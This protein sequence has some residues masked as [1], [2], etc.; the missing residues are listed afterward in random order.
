MLPWM[1]RCMY[2]CFIFFRDILRSA[3]AVSHCSSVLVIS[4]SGCTNLHS[5]PQC[6]RVPFSPHLRQHLY[7]YPFW[8][9]PFWQVRGDILILICISLMTSDVDHLFMCLLAICIYSL[10]KCLISSSAHFLI[11]FF[12]F[13]CWVVWG[14]CIC[15][16]LTSNWSY[17]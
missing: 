13:W 12:A 7:V 3:T 14:V 5:H 10:E 1:L 17:H 11:G 9:K 4:H 15:W 2:W 8:W 16:I 6:T